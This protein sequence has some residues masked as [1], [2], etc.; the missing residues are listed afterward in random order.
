M[1]AA[2]NEPQAVNPGLSTH[3]DPLK[4][5]QGRTVGERRHFKAGLKGLENPRSIRQ[6]QNMTKGTS[7]VRTSAK[8]QLVIYN[9][10]ARA[11]RGKEETRWS[12]DDKGTRVFM[13]LEVFEGLRRS[14]S[15]TSTSLATTNKPSV[16]SAMIW[17][18][19]SDGDGGVPVNATKNGMEAR[20]STRFGQ[21]HM[22]YMHW[23]VPSLSQSVRASHPGRHAC[24]TAVQIVVIPALSHKIK[25]TPGQLY[26][27]ME[28]PNDWPHGCP[29]GQG[30]PGAGSE[31]EEG[32]MTYKCGDLEIAQR[33]LIVMVT[34]T[35]EQRK[36]KNAWN[37]VSYVQRFERQKK[38]NKYGAR[39]GST[40]GCKG[41]VQA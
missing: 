1:R 7:D 24:Q 22:H 37:V 6:A 19:T 9:L 12:F 18:L 23:R 40:E 25:H 20:R 16:G 10:E 2:V 3:L 27:A 41:A 39:Y 33:R 8:N 35:R 29:A 34:T 4:G 5:A 32:S 30:Q 11:D 28:T 21:V 14:Q 13:L 38:R 31:S 15:I 26:D 17:K 36:E